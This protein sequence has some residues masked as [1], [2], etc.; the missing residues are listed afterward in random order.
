MCWWSVCDKEGN[1]P[2]VEECTSGGG[3]VERVWKTISHIIIWSLRLC[4]CTE[5]EWEIG[6]ASC[7]ERVSSPV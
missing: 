2:L 7:R 5:D 4:R 3:G 6:R 1:I